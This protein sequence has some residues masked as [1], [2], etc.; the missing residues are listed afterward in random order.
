MRNFR[1]LLT[2]TALFVVIF[3]LLRLALLLRY[4]PMAEGIPAGTIFQSF[5]V[6]LR[7][8]LSIT[9]YIMSLP[10]LIGMLP[11]VGWADCR[12]TRIISTIYLTVLGSIAFFFT[13]ADLEFFG[14]FNARLNHIALDWSD[15]PWMSIKIT[16]ENAPV[17]LYLLIWA[18]IIA[19]FAFILTRINR[20]LLDDVKPEPAWRIWSIYILSLAL[21]FLAIRGR[22]EEKS[23]INWSV[24]YFSSHH[25]ANQLALN[26]VFTFVRDAILDRGARQEAAS[27]ASIMSDEEAYDGVIDYL[28]I[29]REK[30]TG[31]SPIARLSGEDPARN[32]NVIVIIV[33]SYAANFIKSCGG[34]EDFAPEFDS[35]VDQGMLFT[36][37]FANGG[38]T[39]AGI[40]STVTGLPTPPGRPIMK[41]SEGQQE[42]SGLA[43]ILKRRGYETRVYLTHDPH[44]DNK[45]G[46]LLQ[47]GFDRVVGLFDYEG[48]E[49]LSTVGVAD[50]VMYEYALQDFASFDKPFFAL[51]QTGSNHGP[52]IVPDRPHKKPAP[53][54]EQYDRINA[55]Y[56]T[57]WAVKQFYD[58]V[59]T[60]AYSDSA[61]FVICA[62][63]GTPWHAQLEMDLSAYRIPLFISCPGTIEPGISENIGSLKDIT[64]TVME[65]LG[66]EWIN[67]TMGKSMLSDPPERA[68]FVE[69][70][71]FGMIAGDRYLMQRR[72]G[73]LILYTYPQLMPVLDDLGR[74]K[75]MENY[76]Q[77]F[78][79]ATHY[80]IFD[81]KVG[82]W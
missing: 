16:W 34:A 80:L 67:A 48:A 14:E 1:Y 4:L 61:I 54:Q 15:T 25:F 73:G 23:P 30:L 19:I 70:N 71:S 66:G 46:F 75:D 24:A 38:H 63:N 58:Q 60:S 77:T 53:D 64:T 35:I 22:I 76:A 49:K 10:V 81:R 33:E 26:S 9:G 52:F 11:K 3:E 37:F 74:V 7:F 50:E 72:D 12:L 40:F 42:F 65:V 32:L 44:F 56:Y 31:D 29:D 43:S 2:V 5:L 20:W 78:L 18:V 36:N 59:R 13:L 21:T 27:M 79:A 68:F 57:D 51:L 62:D 47:N 39:Y 17:P 82:V 55:F 8:D 41:I 45:Q 6:G 28:D 69:G